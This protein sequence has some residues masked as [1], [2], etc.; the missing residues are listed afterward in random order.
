MLP[1]PP[2]AVAAAVVA[3]VLWALVVLAS[4]VVEAMA[5]HLHSLLVVAGTSDKF[6]TYMQVTLTCFTATVEATV[7]AVAEVTLL[8]DDLA[9]SHSEVTTDGHAVAK[10]DSATGCHLRTPHGF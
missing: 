9:F 7:A 2:E 1:L 6:L 10:G 4:A 3:A 8:T 5:V